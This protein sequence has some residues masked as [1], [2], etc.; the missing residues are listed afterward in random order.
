MGFLRRLVG[1]NWLDFNWALYDI[2]VNPRIVT[3]ALLFMAALLVLGSYPVWRKR[4]LRGIVGALA[5]YWLLI[6]PPF[7]ALS[8]GLLMSAVPADTGET[9]DAIVVLGRGYEE[10]GDRYPVA[11]QLLKAGRAP[12]LLITGRG[13]FERAGLLLDDYDISLA[14]ISGTTCGRTTKDEAF[15]LSAIL[16]PQGIHRIILITDRPHMLRAYLT[17]RGRGFSVLPHPIDLEIS[18]ARHSMLTL[19]EYV[20]LTSYGLL[21]RLFPQSPDALDSPPVDLVQDVERR[22]CAVTATEK[23]KLL[24]VGQVE[25]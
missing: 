2:L 15:S 12:Q 10:R 5:V 3:L 11:M 13:N 21:G 22:G 6:S 16:G 7:V 4:I 19:R 17:F 23:A 18:S 25:R 8:E 14:Q 9:A 24:Q 1:T 20:G